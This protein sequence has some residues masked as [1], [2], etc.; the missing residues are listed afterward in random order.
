MV[1]RDGA[2]MTG[3]SANRGRLTTPSPRIPSCPDCKQQLSSVKG[4]CRAQHFVPFATV[5]TTVAHNV[6]CFTSNHPQ[7]GTATTSSSAGSR[8][9]ICLSWNKG[10]CVFPSSCTYRHLCATCLQQHKARDCPRTP[11]NS[12]Y[13]RPSQRSNPPVISRSSSAMPVALT[14][15]LNGAIKPET[16]SSLH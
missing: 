1:V 10:T 8:R 2:N 15:L 5:S 3:L 7:A 13:K 16:D 14:F 4:E 11:D 6:P 12:I 9:N